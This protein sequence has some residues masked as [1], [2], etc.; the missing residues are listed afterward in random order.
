MP[1]LTSQKLIVLPGNSGMRGMNAKA[2]NRYTVVTTH[3]T[4]RSASSIATMR[5]LS[6]TRCLAFPHFH[7]SDWAFRS[8]RSNYVSKWTAGDMLQ[9]FRPLLASGRLT[10][11]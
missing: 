6:P 9:S 11:R 3:R 5:C 2:R 8:M 1:E 7:F 4:T 10:R